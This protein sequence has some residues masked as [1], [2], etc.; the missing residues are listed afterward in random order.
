MLPL[1]TCEREEVQKLQNIVLVNVIVAATAVA[2]VWQN[3][4]VAVVI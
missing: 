3:I 2:F 1:A 4:V